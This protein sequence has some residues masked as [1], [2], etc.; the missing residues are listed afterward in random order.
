MKKVLMVCLGNI[1]RSPMAEGILQ[2]KINQQN[3]PISVD[4]A[5]TSN[6][7]IGEAPDQRAIAEMKKYN[8]DIASL[9]ARQFTTQDFDV[10]DEIY[11]MDE[12]NYENIVALATTNEQKQKV[13]LM[14]NLTHPNQNLS[15]PDPYFGGQSGFTHV[16]KMLNDACDK[17]I[18]NTAH[19]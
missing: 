13:K 17:I 3:L 14:L 5:G 6:Y 10:F 2:H 18:E 19:E 4:S 8:I 15:V 7:H 11:A 1:C 9:K 12:S 16:Y